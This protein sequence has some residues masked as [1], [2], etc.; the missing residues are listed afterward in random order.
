MADQHRVP[1]AL[2]GVE[3]PRPYGLAGNLPA[4]AVMTA[5]KPH[6]NG[7]LYVSDAPFV[8]PYNERP[9]CAGT[10]TDGNPCK[11]KAVPGLTHCEHH[12]PEG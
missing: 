4:D 3:N 12:D 6:G 5:H 1:A 2:V 11:A 9:T 8:Q 7:R 10:R